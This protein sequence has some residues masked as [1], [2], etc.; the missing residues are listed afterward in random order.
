MQV[1]TQKKKNS[2]FSAAFLKSTVNFNPFEEKDDP[3][4]FCISEMMDSENVVI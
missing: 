3:H 4:G 2:E 1:S